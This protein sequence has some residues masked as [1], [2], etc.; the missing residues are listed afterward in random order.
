MVATIKFISSY[1]LAFRGKSEV[2][3]LVKIMVI[4]H[5]LWNIYPSSIHFCGDTSK[6]VWN[7]TGTVNYL[8]STKRDE[9]ISIISKDLQLTIVNEIK[10]AEFYSL[11]TDSTPDISHLDQLTIIFPYVLPSGIKERFLGFL[12]IFSH[13]GENLEK[14]LIIFKQYRLN[15]TNCREQSYDNAFLYVRS[16]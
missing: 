7:G 1:S 11:I 10:E 5:V 14:V 8:L 6:K 16:I 15:I 12:P 4:A 13:T 2:F 9:F 3:L